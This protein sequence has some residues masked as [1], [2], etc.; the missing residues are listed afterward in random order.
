M[1]EKMGFHRETWRKTWD[2]TMKNGG[3]W[4]FTILRDDD[5]MEGNGDISTQTSVDRGTMVHD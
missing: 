3:K 1:E 5:L 2:F 4:D